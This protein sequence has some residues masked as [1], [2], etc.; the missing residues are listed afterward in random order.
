MGVEVQTTRHWQRA[1]ERGLSRVLFVNM[2]D[3]ERADFFRVAR[4]HARAALGAV[5]R[6]P[7]ADRQPS[8]S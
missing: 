4:G 3:R 6:R 8:T 7:P 5:R 1:D 2:L